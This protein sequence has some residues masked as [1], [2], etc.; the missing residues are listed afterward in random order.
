MIATTDDLCRRDNAL[1]IWWTPS[2]VGVE[3]NEQADGMARLAAEG[4]REQC[5]STSGRL[6]SP[7]SQGGPRRH[8]PR[9]PAPGSETAWGCRHR[10]SPP[11]GRLC[12]GLAR[13][14]KELAGRFY[15]LLSGHAA[16]GEHLVRIGQAPNDR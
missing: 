15:Q 2:H 7:T 11:R 13:V 16:M 12:K 9:P 1:T 3:G 8:A 10:Y 4:E 5:R 14:R 6:A